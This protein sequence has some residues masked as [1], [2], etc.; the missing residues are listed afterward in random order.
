MMLDYQH[1]AHFL[2]LIGQN[3]NEQSNHKEMIKYGIFE[4][5][6]D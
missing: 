1:V 5:V 4:V 3:K 2:F 6:T